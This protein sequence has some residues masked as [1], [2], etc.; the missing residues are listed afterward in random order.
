M[1]LFHN[2]QVQI[3]EL[4]AQLFFFVIVVSIEKIKSIIFAQIITIV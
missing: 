3:K 2:Q 1:F 4:T